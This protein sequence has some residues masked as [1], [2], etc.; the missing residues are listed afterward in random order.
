MAGIYL[1]KETGENQDEKHK[2]SSNKHKE[3]EKEE[4]RKKEEQKRIEE[5]RSIP[6][7]DK[8]SIGNDFTIFGDNQNGLYGYG[9]TA[10]GEL[11]GKIKRN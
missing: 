1:S 11:G 10:N 8:V 5:I 4:Q 7:I 6:F 9:N 3:K 2:G